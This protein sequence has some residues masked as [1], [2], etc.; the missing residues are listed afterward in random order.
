MGPY[1]FGPNFAF[2]RYS[3]KIVHKKLMVI[4]T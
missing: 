4:I 1:G 2:P 3:F